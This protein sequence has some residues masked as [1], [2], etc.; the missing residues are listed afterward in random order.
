[1]ILIYSK[2]DGGWYWERY[3]WVQSILYP[4]EEAALK[5]KRT[6]SIRWEN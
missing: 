3:D 1:M 5:A 4:T 2:D 6:D